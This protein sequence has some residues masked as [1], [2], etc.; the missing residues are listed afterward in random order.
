MC[1]RRIQCKL[2]TRVLMLDHWRKKQQPDFQHS[3][4]LNVTW[5]HM[6]GIGHCE[7]CNLGVQ[8]KGLL[9]KRAEV[10]LHP[11][12][13]SLCSTKLHTHN[14]EWRNAA[15]FGFKKVMGSI[16]LLCNQMA[17]A[18][19]SCT[20]SLLYFVIKIYFFEEAYESRYIG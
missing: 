8:Y 18:N 15:N 9:K 17:M 19:G 12:H 16:Y 11:Q 13:S 4:L 20:I 6:T 7:K 5:M 2:S 10:L 14:Q 1:S 3:S